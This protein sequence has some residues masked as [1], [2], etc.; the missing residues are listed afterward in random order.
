MRLVTGFAVV[1]SMLTFLPAPVSS[2]TGNTAANIL[3]GA[4]AE[5]V[6]LQTKCE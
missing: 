5:P 4:F 2:A 6:N 3:V 1:G